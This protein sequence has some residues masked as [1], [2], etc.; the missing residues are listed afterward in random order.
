MSIWL[1]VIF[2]LIE[3]SFNKIR[4][5]YRHSLVVTIFAMGYVAVNYGGSKFLGNS[6]LYPYLTVWDMDKESVPYH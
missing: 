6:E 2:S 3:F 5:V 1:P 4:L